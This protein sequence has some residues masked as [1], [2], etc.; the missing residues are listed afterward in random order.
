MP[1][2]AF[3][4]AGVLQKTADLYALPQP[5]LDIEAG[6][7]RADLRLWTKDN[8]TLSISQEAW[9]DSIDNRF[10][11]YLAFQVGFALENRLDIILDTTVPLPPPSISKMID[12]R[13]TVSPKWSPG[14]GFSADGELRITLTP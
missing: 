7:A 3:T 11:N 4:P 10:I 14:S 6:L 8:F 13:G 1:K 12:T 5:D 9:L 2:Q